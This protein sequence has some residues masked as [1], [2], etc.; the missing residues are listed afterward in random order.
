MFSRAVIGLF[1]LVHHSFSNVL[2]NEVHLR[3]VLER[4]AVTGWYFQPTALRTCPDTQNLGMC[5][6]KN[7]LFFMFHL[8]SV[9]DH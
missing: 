4:Q 9:D 8:I 7:H 6:N 5:K 3:G 1:V 2:K